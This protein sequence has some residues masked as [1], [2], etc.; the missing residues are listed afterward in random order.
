MGLTRATPVTPPGSEAIKGGFLSKLESGMSITS[1]ATGTG[2]T[3][4][5]G[6]LEPASLAVTD[7]ERR[8]AEGVLGRAAGIERVQNGIRINR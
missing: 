6:V 5:A 4:L 2:G 8:R 3:P 7:R 1:N